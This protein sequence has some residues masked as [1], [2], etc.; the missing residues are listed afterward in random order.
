MAAD[1]PAIVIRGLSKRFP[2]VDALDSIDLEIRSAEVHALV[3]QNGAGKSTLINILS[4]AL[5]PS[6]GQILLR[7]RPARFGTPLDA[8]TE[9][10][11]AITQE[12][13]LVPTLGA[14]E[15]ILLGRLP[16][17][18]GGRVDWDAVYSRGHDILSRLGFDIDPRV[19]VARL[20]I[21]QQQGVE[22][23]RALSRQAAIVIMDEP[24]SAL[25][26][27]AQRSLMLEVKELQRKI[28]FAVIFVTHDMSLV[29]HF[30]DRLAVMYAGQIVEIGPTQT[31]FDA[32]KHPY[33][34]GLM[35]SFPSI[36]GPKVV[37]TGIH[38]FPPDLRHPPDGCRFHPRCPKVMP[39][40]RTVDPPV[41][42]QGPDRVRCLLYDDGG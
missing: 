2:G 32:P 37:L 42:E 36:R 28:G 22:I 8:I 35:Q 27:V 11:A 7:G 5:A 19:P 9:G 25:D 20:T 15:N 21:A 16:T 17:R 12:I 3:G 10:I 38:G 14:A 26:V 18:G 13:S 6:D 29:S 39:R 24:T 30:S 34:Q 23:A 1:A 33:T 40:C 4:G 41:F 31:L